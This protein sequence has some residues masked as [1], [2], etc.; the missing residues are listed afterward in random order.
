MN[1]LIQWISCVKVASNFLI[2]LGVRPVGRMKTQVRLL[3]FLVRLAG[4]V[5]SKLVGSM[6]NAERMMLC[7]ISS[8]HNVEMPSKMSYLLFISSV[9]QNHRIAECSLPESQNASVEIT[10]LARIAQCLEIKIF[11]AVTWISLSIKSVFL[12]RGWKRSPGQTLPCPARGIPRNYWQLIDKFIED[13][14]DSGVS[15]IL[16]F[17]L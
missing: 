3:N 2:R 4:W 17:L 7:S 11:S 8:I 6:R 5:N 15:V 9:C 14:F 13:G 10:V 16:L 12:R 1:T